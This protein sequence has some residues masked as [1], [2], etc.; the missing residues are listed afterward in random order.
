ML[1]LARGHYPVLITRPLPV[2]NT[3]VGGSI[4]I[5]MSLCDARVRCYA[6]LCGQRPG[7]I[8]SSRTVSFGSELYDGGEMSGCE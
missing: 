7:T 6:A 1:K 8:I 3:V 5:V 4:A 2:Q